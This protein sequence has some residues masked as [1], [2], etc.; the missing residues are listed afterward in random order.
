MTD[1]RIQLK[2]LNGDSNPNLLTY[3]ASLSRGASTHKY[4]IYQVLDVGINLTS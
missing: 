1:T 3:D 2:N 4:N